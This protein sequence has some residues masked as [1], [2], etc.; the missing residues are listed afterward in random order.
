MRNYLM[1][2]NMSIK[3][4]M[5]LIIECCEYKNCKKYLNLFNLNFSKNDMLEF[6]WNNGFEKGLKYLTDEEIKTYTLFFL[7]K[8]YVE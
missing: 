7:C 5:K 4:N 8:N 2:K 6:L 3:E 1:I